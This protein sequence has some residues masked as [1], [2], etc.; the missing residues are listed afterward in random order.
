[1][2][3]DEVLDEVRAVGPAEEV[4]PADPQ[5]SQHRR[6]VV[7]GVGRVDEHGLA[8]GPV[9]DRVHEVDHLGRDGIA[10][11]EVAPRE[12]LA[13]VQPVVARHGGHATDAG[14]HRI[15]PGGTYAARRG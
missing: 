14:A 6:E 1:M 13:E 3:G 7:D 11:R 8:G 12:E 2:T 10:D 15:G 4:D 5:R 9:A